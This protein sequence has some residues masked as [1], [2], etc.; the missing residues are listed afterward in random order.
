MAQ[1]FNVN[2]PKFEFSTTAKLCVRSNQFLNLAVA[3]SPGTV[4]TNQ[5]EPQ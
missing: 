5:Q 3:A 1:A 4:Y 2:K